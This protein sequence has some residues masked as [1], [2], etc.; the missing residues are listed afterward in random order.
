MLK[1][2]VTS[3]KPLVLWMLCLV[4]DHE[5]SNRTYIR[6]FRGRASFYGDPYWPWDL[7]LLGTSQQKFSVIGSEFSGKSVVIISSINIV[8]FLVVGR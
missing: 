7:V 1:E 8:N 4:R 5:D 6:Y 3:T 2:T